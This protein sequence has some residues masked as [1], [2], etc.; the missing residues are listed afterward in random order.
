[1]SWQLLVTYLSSIGVLAYGSGPLVLFA[2]RRTLPEA[3]FPR[4][5]RLRYAMVASALAFIVANLVVFWAGANVSNHLFGGLGIA[6]CAYCAWQLATRRTL[7]HLEWRG[8]WWIAPYF[9][10][11]WFITYLGPLHGT[12]TLGN[13]SG[14]LVLVAFSV[15]ILFLARA[16]ALPDPAEAKAR[17][18][19]GG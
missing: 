13:V 9:A 1:P 12:G 14:L 7:A 2:F 3:Q 11:L 8:A 4:P 17:L 10:G 15:V 6:F 18:R 19:A 16:C 5:F